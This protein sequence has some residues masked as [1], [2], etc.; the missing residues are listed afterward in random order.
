MATFE[1]LAGELNAIVQ[2][3]DEVGLTLDFSVSLSGYT[4]T[5]EIVSLI[6]GDVVSS[7]PTTITD[8][9]NGIANVALSETLMASFAAGTYR[10]NVE[11]VAP[12]DV[13]RRVLSGLFE[14]RR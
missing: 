5:S 11:W 13:A 9:A 1:Q 10:L 4:V 12:G 3:S 6:S 8:A 7:P 14:V 2:A